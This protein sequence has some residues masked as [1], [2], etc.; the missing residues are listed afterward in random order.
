MWKGLPLGVSPNE[1]MITPEGKKGSLGN[2]RFQKRG[3]HSP[4]MRTHSGPL[5]CPLTSHWAF[6]SLL[7]K[8]SIRNSNRGTI[9]FNQS[10]RVNSGLPQTHLHTSPSV[11]SNTSAITAI[12]DGLTRM[13]K[14]NS[15]CLLHNCPDIVFLPL[16][17]ILIL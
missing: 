12:I 5:S 9:V 11:P 1:K 4:R 14:G 8:L 15:F 7:T 17:F 2:L 16:S 13:T 6:I 3:N 10:Y